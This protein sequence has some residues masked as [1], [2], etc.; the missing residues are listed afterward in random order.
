[1]P[2]LAAV[3]QR[4]PF[5]FPAAIVPSQLLLTTEHFYLLAP[6]GQVIEGFLS[7]LT[8]ACRDAPNRLRCLDDIPE[9]WTGELAAVGGLVARFYR[10]VYE[11]PPVFYEHGRGGGHLSSFPDGDFVFHPH[12]CALPGELTIHRVLRARLR[13][14]R[15]PSFPA[16][17]AEI[18]RRAYLYVHT[19]GRTTCSTPIVYYGRE[20]DSDEHLSRF[21]LK[22]LLVEANQLDRET[23]WRR[24]PGER[25]LAVLVDKFNRWYA[26]AFRRSADPQWEWTS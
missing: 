5:C 19:P 9:S 11:A 2:S 15:A 22:E 20:L 6:A 3:D 14:R 17:R 7:I 26:T 16:V 1:M 8:H 18:G 13:H 24:Y 12:L 4:C 21:S 10:E 23:N 25:E